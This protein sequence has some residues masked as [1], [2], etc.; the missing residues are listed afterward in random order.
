MKKELFSVLKLIFV[1]AP[2]GKAISTV[3]AGDSLVA[4]F[5]SYYVNNKSLKESLEYGVCAGS[6]TVFS[7]HL[8]TKE[9]IDKLFLSLKR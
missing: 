9:E 5:L 1:E 2:K 8:A 4:G 6:A 7:H 3:G